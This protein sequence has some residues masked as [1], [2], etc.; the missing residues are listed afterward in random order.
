VDF[1]LPSNCWVSQLEKSEFAVPILGFEKLGLELDN[2]GRT[3]KNA[4]CPIYSLWKWRPLSD[5]PNHRQK[6]KKKRERTV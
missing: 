2:C 4:Y 1:N 6:R 3:T 5:N